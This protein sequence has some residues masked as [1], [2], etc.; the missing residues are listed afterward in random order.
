MATI[1]SAIP[2][3]VQPVRIED[4]LNKLAQAYQ[5][6]GL[7]RQGEMADMQMQQ[8]RQGMERQNKLRELLGGFQQGVTPEQQAAE[9]TRGGFLSEAQS[10]AKTAAENSKMSREA[11]KARLEAL[12]QKIEIG[13]QI[14]GSVTDPNSYQRA[15]QVA[16]QAGFDPWPEQYDPAWVA[17][18]TQQGMTLKDRVD[19][20]WRQTQN[21][22]AIRGQN[23]T[24]RGQDMQNVRSKDY[25]EAVR[26]LNLQQKELQLEK[27]QG[28]RA[29][30]NAAKDAQTA[31]IQ[32][33]LGVI[34]KALNHPGRKTSTGLSG[35][36]DPRNYIPGTDAADFRA[37]LDQIGGTAFLQAFESLKGGGQITEV[38]GRKATEA[39]ARLNRAQSDKEFENSLKDLRAVMVSGLERQ[40]SKSTPA[41]TPVTGGAKFLG[42]E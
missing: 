3:G 12:K 7:Q 30:R 35:T 42:F 17:Q 40:R 10:V 41:A 31:S 19:A 13:G 28:E 27:L 22:T 9:L 38:E 4:P 26:G 32:A 5:V 1:N 33:Q 21:E 29:D 6:Q 18:Q 16:A 39:I 2:M 11:E 8:A 34:D 15:R 36:I 24:M 14:L 23:I 20:A 37:V 25:N